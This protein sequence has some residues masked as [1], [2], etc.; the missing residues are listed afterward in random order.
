[1]C[2]FSEEISAK[3]ISLGEKKDKN[4]LDSGLAG[5]DEF[6]WQDVLVKY[7]TSCS[8][9]DALAFQDAMFEGIDPSIKLNHSWSKLRDIY[10]VLSKDFEVVRDNHKKSG[11]HDDFINFCNNKSEVY[12]LY[13]WL[14]EKPD[15]SNIVACELHD[16]V[17]CD[18]AANVIILRPSPTN[19]STTRQSLVESVN[20]LVQAWKPDAKQIQLTDEKLKGQVSK[21]RDDAKGRLLN[22]KRQLKTETDRGIRK[23]LQKYEKKLIKELDFSSGSSDD[24]S[25]E[26]EDS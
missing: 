18:S 15:V 14:Q 2:C 10:K 7:Q 25:V 26:S 12:Y 24:E 19:S 17:F 22:T 5:F 23:I 8:S 21:N 3:F 20:A 13:L 9:F 1:M 11:N 16:S 6:F 4:V